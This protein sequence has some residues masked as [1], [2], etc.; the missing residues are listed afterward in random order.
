MG[1]PNDEAL[2]VGRGEDGSTPSLHEAV[3]RVEVG[4]H[5]EGAVRG[6]V[7]V[8]RRRQLR[9]HARALRVRN[10]DDVYHIA[11]QE[12]QTVVAERKELAQHA[13]RHHGQK[14][15][16][17]LWVRAGGKKYRDGRF[18]LLDERLHVLIVVV[19]D[20]LRHV[21]EVPG[22]PS[23]EVRMANALETRDDVQH[24][25][26][27]LRRGHGEEAALEGVVLHAN[28]VVAEAAEHVIG[29]DEERVRN[30]LGSEVDVGDLQGDLRVTK[31]S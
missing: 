30:R 10:A 25:D 8:A 17:V 20:G 24:V 5:G 4:G 23:G 27:V 11:G 13:Q 14:H 2:E 12:H 31:E 28:G 18:I 6:D 9:Q 26:V 22:E 15:R 1:G 21:H 29:D 19:V 16:S 7:R 3:E